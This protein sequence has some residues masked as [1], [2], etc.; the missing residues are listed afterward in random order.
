MSTA[1]AAEGSCGCRTHSPPQWAFSI[2]QVPCCCEQYEEV[3]P[4]SSTA[5]EVSVHDEETVILT[6]WP[7]ESPA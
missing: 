4:I 2:I 6:G 3:M 1:S 7:D 5:H